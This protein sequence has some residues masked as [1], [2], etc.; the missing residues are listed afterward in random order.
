M[1]THICTSLVHTPHMH[2]HTHRHAH[3]YTRTQ[4]QVWEAPCHT[5]G[6]VMYVL[7]AK[8]G[9]DSGTGDKSGN[10]VPIAIFTGDTIFAGGTG[11]FFEGTAKE[12]ST[13][14]TRVAGT[15]G[16]FLCVACMC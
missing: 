8:P 3:T 15:C 14:L 1:H 16:A 13:N 2:T 9:N 10:P 11:K 12:M 5:R 4:I 6:H 7:C